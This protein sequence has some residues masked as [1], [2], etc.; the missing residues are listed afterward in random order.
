MS[1]TLQSDYREE[2]R[3]R[4]KEIRRGLKEEE[5]K[6]RSERV[7]SNLY[8]LD[9]FQSA[10][11]VAIYLPKKG[12]GEVDTSPL[13][14]LIGKKKILVPVTIAGSNELKFSEV[15]HEE[16]LVLSELGIPE[17]KPSCYRFVSPS[18]IQLVLVP[19]ICFDKHGRRLGF[20][21]GCYDRF[22]RE[23]RKV[24]EGMVAI[25]LAYDFQVVEEIPPSEVDEKVDMLAT[26]TKIYRFNR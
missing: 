14:A 23:A 10:T 18:E 20:G 1:S 6:L 2:L 5:V 22:L 15:L 9:E 26:E 24:N 17:P 25:G 7:L 12:S 8:T 13:L 11:C 21:R 16:E 4:F 3:K 19:G